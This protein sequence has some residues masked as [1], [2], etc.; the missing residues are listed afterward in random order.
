M[1]RSVLILSASLA[2]MVVAMPVV[3]HDMTGANTTDS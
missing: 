3:A 1:I 2:T